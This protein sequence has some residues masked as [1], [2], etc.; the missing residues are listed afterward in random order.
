MG[1]LYLYLLPSKSLSFEGG[2]RKWVI[3]ALGFVTERFVW[4]RGC[5]MWTGAGCKKN[6]LNLQP[7][8]CVILR[9]SACNATRRGSNATEL[10]VMPRDMAAAPQNTL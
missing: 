3:R 2:E 6:N 8:D 5:V 9:K 10:S 7:V 1:V 4:H